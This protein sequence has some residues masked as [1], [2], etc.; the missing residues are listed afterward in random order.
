MFLHFLD[1]KIYMHLLDQVSCHNSELS[2]VCPA[3]KWIYRLKILY[4]NKSC[5]IKSVVSYFSSWWY[6]FQQD[7]MQNWVDE[8]FY[9]QEIHLMRIFS[10]E[11]NPLNNTKAGKYTHTRTCHKIMQ[12]HV[13][14]VFTYHH[15][16]D[17]T[18]YYKKLPL[19]NMLKLT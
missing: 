14:M 6:R 10:R 16:G 18:I 19:K 12:I 8:D 11:K 9:S 15:L 13:H 5:H 4:F 2:L 1:A 7:S 3:C 17:Y